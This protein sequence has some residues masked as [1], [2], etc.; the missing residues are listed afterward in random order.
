MASA[1]LDSVNKSIKVLVVDDY[2]L[3][4]DMVKSI[5]RQLGFVNVQ[6]VENG[7]AALEVVRREEVGLIICDWNMPCVSG[8]EVLRQVRSLPGGKTRPFLMLTAEAYRENVM[9][10]LKAGVSDYIVKPFSSQTLAEKIALVLGGRKSP[11][12]PR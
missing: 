2:A 8:L 10:A 4:R 5:V 6:S 9:E 11:P 3:T 12:P 1:A 7:Q